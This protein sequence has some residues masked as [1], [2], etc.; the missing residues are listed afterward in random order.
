MANNNTALIIDNI[1]PINMSQYNSVISGE[2][3][4]VSLL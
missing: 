2:S 3:P 4:S 1:A